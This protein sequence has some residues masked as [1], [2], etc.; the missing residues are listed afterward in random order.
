MMSRLLFLTLLGLGL[1]LVCSIP[2]SSVEEVINTSFT[3][4]PG[5]TYGPY[6]PA[7]TGYHTRI[8]F[9]LDKSVLKGDVI[10]EGEGVYLTVNF[11]NTEHLNGIYIEGQYSFTID[12]ADDLYIFTFDNTEGQEESSVRFTLEEMWTRP[13]AFGSPPLFIAGL[14]GFLLF[15]I[16]LVTLTIKRAR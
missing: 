6:D 10:V 4:S 12:P 5:A 11:Y 2:V 15:I 16:G 3:I 8:H 14:T 1:L 13:L 7:G 9:L